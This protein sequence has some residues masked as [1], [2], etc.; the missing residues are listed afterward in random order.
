MNASS[1]SIDQGVGAVSGNSISVSPIATTTYTV[2][3]TNPQ[4]SVTAQTTLIVTPLPPP[5]PPPPTNMIQNPTFTATSSQGAGVVPAHW[6]SGA[7]GAAASAVFSYPVAGV[8]DNF[9]AQVSIASYPATGTGNGAAQWYFETVPVTGG[10]FYSF[11]DSYKSDATNYVVAQWTLSTGANL[12]ESVATLTPTN[13]VWKTGNFYFN[14][15]ANATSL[16][17]LH[18]LQSVGTLV[19]DNYSLSAGTVPAAEQLSNPVV[20]LA[21]DDGLLTQYDNALPILK[22]ANIPASFYIISNLMN[23]VSTYDFFTDPSESITKTTTASG[24]TWSPIY[25]DPTEQHLHFSDAYTSA[26]ASTIV[27]TY[28]LNGSTVNQTIATMPAGTNAHANVSFILPKKSGGNTVSP[29]TIAHTSAGGLTA[30]SPSLTEYGDGYMSTTQVHDVYAAGEEIG[31]HTKT[32]PDLTSLTQANATTEIAGAKSALEAAGFGTISTIA[33]PLGDYNASIEGISASAGLIAGRTTDIGYNGKSTDHMAL[34]TGN[35]DTNT[36]FATVKA[37][38]DTAVAQHLWLTLT[39]HNVDSL[40]NLNAIGDAYGTTPE[41]LQQIVSY[42]AS[43]QQNGE[44][45]VKTMHDALPL[46][47]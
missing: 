23:A 19:V 41:I 25:M 3:A 16:T 46:A 31:D 39:I 28:T 2:T 4:G 47:Q 43:K 14:A 20:T 30:S 26:S 42:L 17:I 33:Y 44:L 7:W 1:T 24:A 45:L 21:F 8:D 37:W 35:V 27:A 40:A 32:H 18:Q 38:I 29:I 22:A 15:P 5:P 6:T 10:S 34:K 9:A 11:S 13:G 12:Y 36:S